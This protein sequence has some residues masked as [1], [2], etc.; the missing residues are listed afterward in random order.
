MTEFVTVKDLR[1]SLAD[2]LDSDLGTYSNGIKRI[3][4]APP[5]APPSNGEGLECIIQRQPAGAIRNSSGRQ[6][7]DFREWLVTLVNY[8]DDASL[9]V[10]AEKVKANYTFPRGSPPFY[11][12]PTAETFEQISF[13][14]YDPILINY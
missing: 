14:I 9:S 1:D 4:V 12:P 2:L 3:W 11:Q 10:A 8:A 7:K 6:K 13:Q 5:S